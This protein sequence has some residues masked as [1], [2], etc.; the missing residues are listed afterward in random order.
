MR[1]RSSATAGPARVVLAARIRAMFLERPPIALACIRADHHRPIVM[2]VNV[3][4]RK[5]DIV[6][7]VSALQVS[8]SGMQ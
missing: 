3:E 1:M 7:R 8:G 5:D 4:I 6:R 2:L